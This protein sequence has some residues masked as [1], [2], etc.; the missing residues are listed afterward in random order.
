MKAA[1][2]VAEYNPFH[3]GHAYH[4]AETRRRL[5]ADAGVICVQ[6]GNWVQRGECALTDKWTRAAMALRGGA[7]L[8]LELPLPWAISSAEGFAQGAVAVLKATGVVDSLSFGSESGNLEGI[9]QVAKA[10]ETDI[11]QNALQEELDKGNSFAEARQ[12]AVLRI[13]GGTG[14]IL[15]GA[16]DNLGVEYLR[17][18]GKEFAAMAIPRQGVVHDST[19]P[20]EGF[21]SASYLRGLAREQ[22]WKEMSSWM[23]Q[24]DLKDL[25]EAGVSDMSYVERAVLAQLR[26]MG[27]REFAALPDSGAAEGLPARLARAARSAG[28]LEEFYALAKTKRY[29]HSRIRRLVLWA[30]LNMTEADRPRQPSYLRVLGFNARGQELLKEMKTTAALPVLTKPAHIREFSVEAQRLFALECRATDLFGL[31]FEIPKPAGLD[32]VT[33]PIFQ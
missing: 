11:F 6:S 30:F 21:A 12:R 22:K 24:E 26:R 1:G 7:D 25:K 8:I 10:L 4:I 19:R 3:T 17:A 18:A 2:I 15:S 23:R 20:A 9:Y 33:T 27:E 16:N 32:L 5:G 28:S 31:C 13:T 29:A 14:S